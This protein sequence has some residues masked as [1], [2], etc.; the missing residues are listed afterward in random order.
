M[1]KF[2]AIVL[3]AITLLVMF[4]GCSKKEQ[5][6]ETRKANPASDFEY[7]VMGTDEKYV[8]IKKYIGKNTDVI[9]PE[10]IEKLPVKC[11][12]YTAFAKTDIELVDIPDSVVRIFEYAF[13][14]CQ[15]LHTV[16]MGNGV[17]EVYRYAFQNCISLENLTL[18]KKL[19]RVETAAF[20]GC[21]SLTELHIPKSLN[22]W[23]GEAFY[24]NSLTKLTFEDGIENIG[25]YAT[26]WDRETALKEVTFPA[27]VKKL[28]EWTFG[29]GVEHA[30]FL[31]DAPEFGN[32]PF[33]ESQVT[34]HYK[35]GTKGWD[36]TGLEEWYTLVED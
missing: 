1:R 10:E 9:I 34:I 8:T 30:Y 17:E 22:K 5:E 21:S 13:Y 20:S 14:S 12:Y 3:A 11:I 36:S 29:G 35:K 2:L 33:G 4:T 15:K 7:E 25:G 6:Q 31:G 27:S 28:G 16:K 32:K 26:L 18:S 19:A 23:Y 24:G